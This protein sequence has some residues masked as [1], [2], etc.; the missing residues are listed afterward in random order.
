M[1]DWDEWCLSSFTKTRRCNECSRC[2]ASKILVCRSTARG[3]YPRHILKKFE[4]KGYDFI[5]EEDK[6][7][8]AEGKVDYI[9]F[10]YYMSFATKYQGRNEKTFDYVPEDFVRN[11]YLKASDWGGGGMAN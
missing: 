9:G 11:T 6:K 3:H 1:Y 4:R 7:I 10:S 5:T 8:L 2:N